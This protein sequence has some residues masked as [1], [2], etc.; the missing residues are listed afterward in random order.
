MDA[1]LN[2]DIQPVKLDDQHWVDVILDGDME[3][4][5]PFSDADEAETVAA[6]LRRFSRALR[7][8]VHA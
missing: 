4:H 6:R 3:R 7:A 5:G 2:V 1:R 8:R